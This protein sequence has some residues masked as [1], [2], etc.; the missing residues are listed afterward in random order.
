MAFGF[1]D[2]IKNDSYFANKICDDLSFIIKH[3][4]DITSDE[5]NKN[6]ILLDSM[7]FRLIQISEN[8]KSLSDDYKKHHSYVPW[9][10]IYGLRNK[11][12][13]DYGSVD[14]S[15]VYTTLKEDI[16]NLLRIMSR[17]DT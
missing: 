5:L 1:M 15:I 16:P 8:A 3:T 11:I 10:A 7:M 13:H 6:E 2:N 17:N 12:V 9:T 14:L 4:K